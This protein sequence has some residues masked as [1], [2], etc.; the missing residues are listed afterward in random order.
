MDIIKVFRDFHAGGKFESS[1]NASFSV[2]I[3]KI[4]GVVDLKD[5]RL[6]SLMGDIYKIIATILAN[7]LKLVLENIIS[8]S[9]NA[10][11]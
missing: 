5:F 3:L 11:I 7:R 10:F 2:L 9:R 6:I 1:L 8:K 4:Q